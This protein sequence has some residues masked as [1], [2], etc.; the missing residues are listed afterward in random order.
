[1]IICAGGNYDVGD[2]GGSE[3]VTTDSTG[4]HSHDVTVDSG[5]SHSHTVTVN[6]HTLTT[7]QIPIHNH[8]SAQRI[9]E[10]YNDTS[11]DIFGYEPAI[12]YPNNGYGCGRTE[13]AYPMLRPNTSNTGSSSSHNHT[14][15]SNSTG[16]HTHS[17]SS[18]STGNHTHTVSTM[19][20]YYALAFIIKL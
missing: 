3:T 11:D 20:P 13:G 16:S 8:N 19:N 9:T 14:A 18:N 4:S 12:G 15:S 7:N 17:A 2:T 10:G 6:S 5:G 1:M